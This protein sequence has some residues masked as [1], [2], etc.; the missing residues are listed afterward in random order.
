VHVCCSEQYPLRHSS[1]LTHEL[2]AALRVHTSS[3]Q[4]PERHSSSTE[5][6][7]PA[8]PGKQTPSHSADLQSAPDEQLRPSSHP[9]HPPP[10]ST[11]LS[12]PFLRESVHV[13]ARH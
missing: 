5:H 11:S 8:A 6:G 2:P 4:L 9:G 3:T 12:L 7:L 10:Q 13:A 1:P